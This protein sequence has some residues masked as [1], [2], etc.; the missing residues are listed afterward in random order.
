MRFLKLS[1]ELDI[2]GGYV[3][4]KYILVNKARMARTNLALVMD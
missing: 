3:V 2:G 4:A 1:F